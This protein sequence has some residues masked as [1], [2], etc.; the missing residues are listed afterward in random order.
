MYFLSLFAICAKFRAEKG[1]KNFGK[2][3]ERYHNKEE[4]SYGTAARKRW[5]YD[6]VFVIY[7]IGIIITYKYFHKYN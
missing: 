3:S 5:Y 1:F 6:L 4:T 7:I 2:N